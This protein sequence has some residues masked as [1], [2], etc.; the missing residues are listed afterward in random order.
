MSFQVGHIK[1]ISIRLHFT[2]IITFFL[3]DW[4]LST[5]FMPDYVK[6]LTSADYWVMSS[7]ATV[8]LFFSILL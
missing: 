8:F 2:L 1:G 5:Y 7:V 3:I 6:G 4:T